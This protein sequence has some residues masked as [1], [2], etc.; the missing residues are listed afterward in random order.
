MTITVNGANDAP[1]AVDD[2]NAATEDGAVVTG[3]VA[4]SDTD[5]DDGATRTYALN[6][7]LPG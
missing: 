3:T 1:V 7:R 6:A 5:V 4:T 2:V